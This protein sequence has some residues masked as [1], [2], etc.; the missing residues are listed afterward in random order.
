MAQIVLATHN[1]HKVAEFQGMQFL[2]AEMAART[3]LSKAMLS[4]IENA[5]T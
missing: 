3:G 4:K 1:A 2:L 5:Q